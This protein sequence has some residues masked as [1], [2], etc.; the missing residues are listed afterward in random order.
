MGTV[1]LHS[2]NRGNR[3]ISIDL[4]ILLQKLFGKLNQR[5]VPAT[6]NA[7][8]V[9][10]GASYVLNPQCSYSDID[11]AIPVS[12]SNTCMPVK[13]IFDSIRTSVLELIKELSHGVIDPESYLQ[14]SI[15]INQEV[16]TNFWS[17]FALRNEGG[18]HVELK[19][20]L[21]IPREYIFFSDSIKIDL[22]NFAKNNRV[23][24]K[25][26]S[27]KENC[28]PL[29]LGSNQ[30][31]GD[32]EPNGNV[33]NR[34]YLPSKI[35]SYYKD[36]KKAISDVK[37]RSIDTVEPEKIRG[38]GFLKYAHLKTKGFVDAREGSDLEQLFEGMVSGFRQE[39]KDSKQDVLSQYVRNHFEPHH[40]PKK[41]KFLEELKSLCSHLEKRGIKD[42]MKTRI[43]RIH[44]EELRKMAIFRAANRHPIVLPLLDFEYC[45][46][47]AHPFFPYL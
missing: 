18:R 7:Y 8:L 9:G 6:E 17:L 2:K 32:A 42:A 25:E 44:K 46:N 28:V 31:A 26:K 3:V 20:V 14:K 34:E 21:S 47:G 12:L 5:K 16:K 11:I 19:F 24:R 27:E 43:E 15:L 13:T 33:E 39:L 40:F 23:P 41:F 36:L 38:G 1:K 35:S 37:S 4:K 22:T 29:E 30:K 10:G 45:S